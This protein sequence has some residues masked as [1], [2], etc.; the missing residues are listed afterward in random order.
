MPGHPEHAWRWMSASGR[1][2]VNWSPLPAGINDAA[3]LLAE[4]L[5][6]L[7]DSTGLSLAQLA[8]GT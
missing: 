2:R 4:E 6:F 1:V 5:R 3:R 7:K 8:V